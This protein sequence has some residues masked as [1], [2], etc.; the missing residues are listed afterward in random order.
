[1]S[2]NRHSSNVTHSWKQ[3][4]RLD[5]RKTCWPV[6]SLIWKPYLGVSDSSSELQRLSRSINFWG[7]DAKSTR[8]PCWTFKLYKD[9]EK[10]RSNWDS[11]PSNAQA[12]ELSINTSENLPLIWRVWRGKRGLYHPSVSLEGPD[13]NKDNRRVKMF[14]GAF[15][16]SWRSQWPE[17]WDNLLNVSEERS[18]ESEQ[19]SF[20]PKNKGKGNGPR[21]E[22]RFFLSCSE[23]VTFS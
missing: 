5:T 1:M 22:D 10:K 12:T 6:I 11:E 13:R 14:P 4:T 17:T 18:S 23:S 19:L 8:R 21:V 20:F 15:M 16:D 9:E 3:L 7:K 2:N